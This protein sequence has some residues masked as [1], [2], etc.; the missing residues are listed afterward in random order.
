M[1]PV[2]KTALL[3]FNSYRLHPDQV[4]L[5]VG[6]GNYTKAI[7]LEGTVLLSS[8][9]LAF[10]EEITAALGFVRVHKSFIINSMYLL[11]VEKWFVLLKHYCIP[12]PIARRRRAQLRR[13]SK[14]QT[15]SSHLNDYEK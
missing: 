6:D 15:T 13:K 2:T 9:N 11:H 7:L 14:L 8:K 1:Q 4:L 10:Y 3:K 12:I 5:L